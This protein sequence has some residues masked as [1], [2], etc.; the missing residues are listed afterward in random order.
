MSSGVVTGALSQLYPDEL[1]VRV[2]FEPAG[3]PNL[4]SCAAFAADGHW[5]Y[6]SDGLV[7]LGLEV[8]FRLKQGAEDEPPQWPFTVLNK[9]GVVMRSNGVIEPGE[10]I[11][12]QG[13]ITGH[14]HLPGSEPSAL[15]GLAFTLDMQLG[16][17]AEAGNEA[18]TTVT[19]LQAIGVTRAELDRM[20][21][22][23]TMAVLRE[24]ADGNPLLVTDPART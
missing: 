16:R 14:P 24:L 22:V 1:P 19:F 7:D 17:K 10:R 21:E 12:L 4:T 5:H 9:L 6:V 13:A 8:T 20:H 3:Q 15:I 23:G 18:A 2:G 11:D